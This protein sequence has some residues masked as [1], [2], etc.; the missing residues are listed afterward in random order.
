MIY[1][2]DEDYNDLQS[3]AIELKLRNY[4]VELIRDADAAF[5]K[6][7]DAKDIELAIVD[8]MLATASQ[9]ESIFSIA[10]TD[11]FKITGLVLIEKLSI[12]NKDFFPKKS[13][14]FSHAVTRNLIDKINIF[15]KENSVPFLS[16]NI[17][18]N[19]FNFANEIE[20]ILKK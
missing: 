16:K 6:L 20:K 18:S 2:I 10:E 13:V 11:Y 7:K 3:F 14:L 1:I 12:V 4:S 9:D 17:F 5:E 8:V 19:T 15:S